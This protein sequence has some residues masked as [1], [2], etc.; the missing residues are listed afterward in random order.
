MITKTS[1]LLATLAMVGPV[2]AFGANQP[3]GSRVR[4]GFGSSNKKVGTSTNPLAKKF[5]SSLKRAPVSQKTKGLAL[6]LDEEGQ[7]DMKEGWK[8]LTGYWTIGAIIGVKFGY[9]SRLLQWAP[10]A[11]LNPWYGLAFAGTALCSKMFNTRNT[12]FGRKFEFGSSA[13]FSLANGLAES[14]LFLAS[15]DLGRKVLGSM[16][17]MDKAAGIITGF[18]VYSIYSA[19]VHLFFWLPKGFPKHVKPTAPKFERQGLP[20]VTAMSLI[21]FGIYE[22]FA[23][24]AFFCLLHTFF[25]W[26]GAVVMAMPGPWSEAEPG[27][28]GSTA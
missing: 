23:D 15:Y 16:F 5:E 21:W 24:V 10:K 18:S 27:L 1:F 8:W 4:P 28:Q 19:I 11:M 14:F 12:T 2:D 22:Q 25:D 26:Q 6:T 9:F 17:N 20:I 3:F 7:K 13:A